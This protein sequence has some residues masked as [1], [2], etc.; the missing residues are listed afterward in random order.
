MERLVAFFVDRRLLVNLVTVMV[1]VFG[2]VVAS[3]LTRALFPPIEIKQITA[4]AMLPG[5][6]AVDVERFITFRI[7][8]AL[9]GL[10]GLEEVTSTTSNGVAVVTLA[11]EAGHDD[12]GRS[13]EEVRSRLASIRHRLPEDMLPLELKQERI[14]QA[15]SFHL[16]VENLD[17]RDPDHRRSVEQ[18]EE[19]LRRIPGVVDV[20]TTLPELDI[21]ISFDRRKL[22]RAGVSAA[23]ARLK[24]LEFLRYAPVGEIQFGDEQIAVELYK[25][26]D[27]LD[28]LRS[29]P[30]VVNRMGYGTTLGQVA[31]VDFQYRER[32]TASLLDGNEFAEV[33]V[34]TDMRTDVIDARDRVMAVIDDE[35]RPDLPQPLQIEM[36]ADAAELIEH[37]LDILKVNGVGGIAIVLVVLMVF[38]GWR[39]SAMTAIG[40]PFCYLGTI[41]VLKATGINFN[42]ISLVAMILVI[43]ILVDDAIIVAEEFY[44][45]RAGGKGARDAAISAVMRVGKPVAG[46]VFTTVVAFTPLLFIK[47][48]LSS[49]LKPLPV[50]II[51]ALLLSLFESM[52][53]LP[54][55]LRDLA[56]SKK[57]PR[58]RWFVRLGRRAYRRVLAVVLFLRYPA[59]GF[60][61]ALVALAGYLLVEKMEVNVSGLSIGA[62]VNIIVELPPTDSMEQAEQRLEPLHRIVAE[63]PEEWH[64]Y[65]LT[66]LGESR[67]GAT[68]LQGFEHAMIAIIPP[69]TMV[70]KNEKLPAIQE[71]L[72]AQFT[73]LEGYEKL[74]V[75]KFG[76]SV[77]DQRDVVTVYVSGGDRIG[78]EELQEAIRGAIR[79][80]DSVTDIFMDDS[81]FQRSVRFV[82]DERAILS[83]GLGTS[84]V[85]AELREHFSTR[86]IARVRHQ[87][88]EFEV[89][90][91]FANEEEPSIRD[92]G[93]ISMMTPRGIPVPLS[94]LGAWEESTVLR[95]IEHQDMLRMFRIDVLF[96]TESVDSDA[97]AEAIETSLDPVRETYPTYYISVTPGE[98]EEKMRQWALIAGVVCVGLIFLCLAL[99][100]DSLVQPIVVLFAIPF[101][102]VGVVL[103]LYLHGMPLGIM[104]VIG[105]FGL[106]GVVVNDSIVMTSTINRSRRE[107]PDLRPKEAVIDGASARFQAVVLTTVT[108]LGGVL[109]LAYGLGGEAGWIQPMVFSLGWGLVFAT[110]LTLMFIPCLLQIID[111]WYRIF[112]WLWAHIP[113]TPA[114][115]ERK[116]AVGRVKEEATPTTDPTTET[117][118]ETEIEIESENE[119]DPAPAPDPEPEE[120]PQP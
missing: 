39:V 75:S 94:Y 44:R 7:E 38:L 92:L 62:N 69:G 67:V 70:E 54:N 101:G 102:F 61:A 65:H 110:F 32:L 46:M 23:D 115:R 37:E 91:D 48:P 17:P 16:F 40:I 68:N 6:S 2:I 96:D 24:V 27:T 10:E 33:V 118:I 89:F 119:P 93:Q 109:P 28:D 49:I 50:V 84:A 30:L 47:G 100:L 103:A 21:D 59:M 95:H 74:Y 113:L 99:A 60:V 116:S 35:I 88:K 36:G 31:D 104:S 58:E 120:E 73:D 53:I 22:D 98:D 43:G 55:H 18:F 51:A 117:E 66:Y 12:M 9:Q 64:Q 26:L 72:E 25:P 3:Q 79:S 15:D 19:S 52:L 20:E 14:S 13:M 81:R 87:G 97:V 108:T 63:L 106:A 56:S 82:P 80:V 8:E 5:A 77:G 1:C 107:K 42:M 90:T 11:F 83:Y 57:V 105:L 4:T 34:F 114:W 71:H 29:L 78:F 111:D 41:L 86:E 85:A 45:G 76:E 112:G